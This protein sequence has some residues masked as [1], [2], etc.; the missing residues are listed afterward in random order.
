M[1]TFFYKYPSRI[2]C[3]TL[4]FVLQTLYI[5]LISSTTYVSSMLDNSETLS[6]L[7]SAIKSQ[8]VA[9]VQSLLAEGADPNER[10]DSYHTP[11]M[12][13]AYV[14]NL[15]IIEQLL[16]SGAFMERY[17]N[18]GNNAFMYAFYGSND[19]D[20][21]VARFME[22]NVNVEMMNQQQMT[23]LIL[24]AKNGLV[25]S[26]EI[27]LE[28]G[29]HTEV[30]GENGNTALLDAVCNKRRDAVELLIDHGANI[31]V[32]DDFS[33]TLLME[34]AFQNDGQMVT[35]LLNKGVDPSE[36]TTK[37]V[38]VTVKKDWR[39]FWGTTVYI[40]VGSTALDIARQFNKHH[41]EHS[42]EYR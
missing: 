38:P 23:P 27:L 18:G 17:D 8:N 19:R 40:P 16:S 22:L 9:E 31:K 26:L 36:T 32:R 25:K 6:P 7:V 21:V 1:K 35:L 42:L 3:Y 15:E 39:D 41:S 10:F 5:S 11:L 14:G 20:D 28:A 12:A 24:A 2:T 13:A 29:A 34:A 4:L 33:M 37:E 30:K